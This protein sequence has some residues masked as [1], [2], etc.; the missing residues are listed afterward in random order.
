MRT[1]LPGRRLFR[2]VDPR[3]RAG[4]HTPV[5]GF[6]PFTD[7]AREVVVRSREDAIRLGFD[8]PGSEHFLLALTVTGRS[9]AAQALNRLGIGPDA[10]REQLAQ[11]AAHPEHTAHQP[12][13]AS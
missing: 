1:R 7:D 6:I 8:H 2:A 12:A 11:L 4:V 10:I 13:G 3:P 5:T 9:V